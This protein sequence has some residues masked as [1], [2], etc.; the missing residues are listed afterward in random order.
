MLNFHSCL[1]IVLC[2]FLLT[3]NG[4]NKLNLPANCNKTKLLTF[5]WK[6]INFNVTTIFIL[7]FINDVRE[8]SFEPKGGTLTW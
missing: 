6:N 3:F 7:Y 8:F 1:M 4:N 5:T 2:N